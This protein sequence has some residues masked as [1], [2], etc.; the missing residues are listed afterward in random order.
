MDR[1][2]EMILD[3]FQRLKTDNYFLRKEKEGL[4]DII[5]DLKQKLEVDK[6]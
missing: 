3:E 5:K 4:E 2:L 6:K 1:T